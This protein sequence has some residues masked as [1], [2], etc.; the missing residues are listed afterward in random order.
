MRRLSISGSGAGTAYVWR[1]E[2]AGGLGSEVLV[3]I[4]LGSRR[5]GRRTCAWRLQMSALRRVAKAF[6]SVPFLDG[7]CAVIGDAE[8]L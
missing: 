5:G 3:R 1:M 7:S 2:E 6:C 4:Q 8:R